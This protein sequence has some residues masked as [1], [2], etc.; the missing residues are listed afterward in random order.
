ME[1]IKQLEWRY[2]TKKFDANKKVSEDDLEVLKKAIQLS[3]S[4]YGLQ[5]Y[6]VLVI[7]NKEI[8]KK[9]KLASWNQ[10]QV[11]DA[12]H[13]FVFCNYTD[14]K[15]ESIDEFINLT[16][17]IR[18]LSLEKLQGYGDFI[19]TK[20]E[21]KSAAERYYWLKS[22]T[23]IAL[24]NLLSA[25]AALKIDACPMEGFDAEEYN[26]ILGLRE[27]ELNASVIVA[28]GYRSDEDRTQDLPKVRKPAELLFQSL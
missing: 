13:L 20:L 23:Y 21:E 2:A 9:L 26:S 8:R 25:C 15:P 28:V 4:S 27:N 24:A 10:S 5:L 1:F 14:A 17:D 18:N 7:E 6:K 16:A 3:V 12:S 11:T 19:K 22:Q